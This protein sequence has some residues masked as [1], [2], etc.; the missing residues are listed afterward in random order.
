MG[1]PKRGAKS[2]FGGHRGGKSFNRNGGGKSGGLRLAMWDFGH[3]NPNACSGK[4]LERLGLIRSL[5][6]GQKSRG[7]VVTPNGKLPVS[8]ADREVY[9]QGG[10]AVVECSW[11]RL[12]E[13]PFDRI[14]GRCE[15][16]LP[17]LVASNP[18]NYGRPWRLN[19]AEALAACLYIVGYPEEAKKLMDSFTWG[20]AFFEVNEELLNI[21]SNCKSAEEVSAAEK[22]YLEEMEEDYQAR[23]AEPTGSE[24]ELGNQNRAARDTQVDEDK[25]A[26]SDTGASAGEP[27]STVSEEEDDESWRSIVRSRLPKEI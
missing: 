23:R 19:C 22:R 1:P 3:C 9:E 21:Y 8:P 4:R 13:V 18:V 26:E 16:L 5:R 27:S 25:P 20:H 17:Y 11:A 2:H 6:V 10:A 12:E 7:V 24:W 15:R 14:G